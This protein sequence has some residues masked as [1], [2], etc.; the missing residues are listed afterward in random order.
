M[1]SGYI[2]D[3]LLVM[4]RPKAEYVLIGL[5]DYSCN[6]SGYEYISSGWICESGHYS[7]LEGYVKDTS[8]EDD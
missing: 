6:Y 8:V 7:L 2:S 3:G 5:S 1:I 4:T